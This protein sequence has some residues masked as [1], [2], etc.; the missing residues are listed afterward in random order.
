MSVRVARLLFPVVLATAITFACS[1]PQSV[2]AGVPAA[3]SP[4]NVCVHLDFPW[5]EWECTDTTTASQ[6][7]NIE[8]ADSV[9]LVVKTKA[10]AIR[11]TPISP[12]ADAI[13]LSKR[14]GDSI[15]VRYYRT[16]GDTAKANALGNRLRR[17]P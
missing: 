12:R 14:A 2:A 4:A 17:L 11:V 1:R 6:F 16:I 9:A 15:L 5:S 10:G 3:N 8:D 13:F 7:M